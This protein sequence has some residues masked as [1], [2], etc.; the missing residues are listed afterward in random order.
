LIEGTRMVFLTEVVD[1]KIMLS[2]QV[3]EYSFDFRLESGKH[4]PGFQ[5]FYTTYG[6]LSDNRDNVVWVCHAL[7]GSSD[8]TE[9]WGGLFGPGKMYDS[10]KY[11][12]ICVN[13]LGGCYGSTGPFSVNSL[14]GKPFFHSFPELTNRDIVSSYELLRKHLG[15]SQIHTII[16]GSLGGQQALEWAIE[17]PGVFQHLV[18]IA[19]NARHS[20]WGI[21]FNE[22]QRMAISQDPSW[23]EDKEDA[24]L[25][26]MKVARSIALLSYRNYQT[27]QATQLDE[28]LEK[29]N[30]YRASSYQVYQGEKLAKR[31]NAFTYWLLSKA[32]DSHNVGRKR[33]GL[34]NALDKIKA[35]TLVVGITSDVLFP[36]NE[37]KFIA[38]Q[39][40]G[41][42]YVEIDSIYG[43]DGFLVEIDKL[44]DALNE[45]YI[46]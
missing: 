12:I 37:Q 35:K 5:L 44:V 15:F 41:A 19:S 43:H 17:Q 4:L 24:G 26:G 18:V 25:N 29:T 11:F 36:V 33:G 3:F 23:K 31:F 7:T 16:G 20:P 14:T 46:S 9:W 2:H 21:A 40:K 8:F 45:F 22:S 10:R 30:N 38:N 42:K 13:T 34:V 32:M 1:P 6:K 28:D 39:V 27:Y